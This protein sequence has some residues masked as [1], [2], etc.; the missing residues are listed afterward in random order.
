[1]VAPL[2]DVHIPVSLVDYLI[3]LGS[4]VSQI[5]LVGLWSSLWCRCSSWLKPA[6]LHMVC[7]G[8]GLSVPMPSLLLVCF[9]LINIGYRAL[10]PKNGILANGFRADLRDSPWLELRRVRWVS[11][12]W[13]FPSTVWFVSISWFL[14][15]RVEE[16]SVGWSSILCVGAYIEKEVKMEWSAWPW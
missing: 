9:H 2:G 3:T 14:V 10:F 12:G 7:G 1:M 11:W 13:R 5:L 8:S 16:R 15:N 4:A 6:F